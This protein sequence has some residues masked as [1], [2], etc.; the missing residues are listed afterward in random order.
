M[1]NGNTALGFVAHSET[2]SA[3]AT[4]ELLVKLSETVA[5]STDL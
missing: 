1:D 2:F 3:F 5:K 4:E